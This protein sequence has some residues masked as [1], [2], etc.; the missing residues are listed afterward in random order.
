MRTLSETRQRTAG[1]IGNK[2]KFT[3]KPVS[4]ETDKPLKM[5]EREL[6]PITSQTPLPPG[7]RKFY[8]NS[9]DFKQIL[10]NI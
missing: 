10:R 4:L 2:A 3:T 5:R 9:I 7:T 8:E 6:A 1:L